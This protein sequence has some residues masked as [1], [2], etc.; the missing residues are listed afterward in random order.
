M[1]YSTGGGG[2]QNYQKILEDLI[3]ARYG[4][5]VFK[6]LLQRVGQ[7]AVAY[8]KSDAPVLTGDIV[9]K[10]GAEMVG[11]FELEI[12]SDS[13]HSGY[14]NDGTWKMDANPFFDRMIAIAKQTLEQETNK[15]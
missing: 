14:V 2:G 5:E 3:T 4:P 15:L 8:G 13:G 10:I 7:A 6:A 1:S 12:F 9:S 11:E